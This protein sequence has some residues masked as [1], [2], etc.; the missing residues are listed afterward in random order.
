MRTSNASATGSDA[1]EYSCWRPLGWARTSPPATSFFRC[2]LASEREMPAASARAEPDIGV[3]P[4]RVRSICAR[5]LSAISAATEREGRMIK[6]T[7]WRIEG[8]PACLDEDRLRDVRGRLGRQP[9][10]VRGG[11]ADEQRPV[12]GLGAA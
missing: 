2:A 3:P 5:C 9:E 7:E 12:P 8:K 6:N 1:I 11:A 10:P 4:S